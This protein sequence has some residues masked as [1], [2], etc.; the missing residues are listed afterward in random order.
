MFPVEN[1]LHWFGDVAHTALR[2]WIQEILSDSCLVSSHSESLPLTGVGD[3]MLISA[4]QA[5]ARLT[6]L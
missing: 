2:M 3:E 1:E 6:L 4:L 5:A